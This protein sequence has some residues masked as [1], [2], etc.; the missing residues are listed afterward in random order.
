MAWSLPATL[1][2][3]ARRRPA[4]LVHC[5]LMILLAAA[6]TPGRAA[7]TGDQRDNFTSLS[8]ANWDLYN[9][10]GHDGNGRRRPSQIAV[11]NGV[12][13]ITGTANGTTGG[14]KWRNRGQTYGQWDIRL[15]AR[16]GCIC[17]HPVVLLWGTGG[18]SGVNN[19]RGELDIV[20]AW[21]RPWRDRNSFTIHYGDGS[22]MV[23]ADTAVD[24]TV[25]HTY[26]LVWQNTYLYTW[27]D[28]NPA[29]FST[30]DVGVLPTGPMD[31]TIQLDWFPQEGTAG[32][33]T[34]TMEVDSVS[35]FVSPVDY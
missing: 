31:L 19:P 13:K 34:A 9:S 6:P 33:A 27:I 7:A 15:R 25:W 24:M 4:W 28:D 3:F 17:Y 30:D 21:Q 35:Q 20:E 29:Y 26:H 1:R 16:A 22:A 11:S 14:M 10:A 5:C 12:L 2:R 32:G 23:G 8:T 18:G